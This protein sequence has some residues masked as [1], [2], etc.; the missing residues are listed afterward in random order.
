MIEINLLPGQKR[1]AAGGPGLQLP[2]F[3]AL[4]GG[5]KDPLLLGTIG[6]WVL[7]VLFSAWLFFSLSSQVNG[8]EPEVQAVRTEA[9]NYN[10]LTAQKRRT[11]DLRDSLLAELSSIRDIDSDRYIWPHILEEVTRAVPDYTWLVGLNSVPPRPGSDTLQDPPV[12]F[13]INGRTA[14]IQAYTRFLR[15]LAAS[16]WVGEVNAGG[17]QTVIEEQRPVYTF[18]VTVSF[19]KADSAFIQTRPILRSVN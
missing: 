17:T 13:N 15:Q 14:D 5:A 16:P 1:K 12:R 8:L 19:Q 4:L 18:T 9:R 10:R 11:Q 2:D 3:A 7:A 6:V